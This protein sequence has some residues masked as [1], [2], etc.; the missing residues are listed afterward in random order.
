VFQ[1]RTAEQRREVRQLPAAQHVVKQI[2]RDAI[3]REH[4]QRR[5]L[6]GVGSASRFPLAQLELFSF[7]DDLTALLQLLPEAAREADDDDQDDDSKPQARR[8]STNN[9]PYCRH[10]SPSCTRRAVAGLVEPRIVC[11]APSSSSPEFRSSSVRPSHGD[12]LDLRPTVTFA[13]AVPKASRSPNLLR[14]HL[15]DHRSR[16]LAAPGTS[17]AL[18]LGRRS[19]SCPQPHGSSSSFSWFFFLAEVVSIF[20]VSRDPTAARL[21]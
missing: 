14:E 1:L 8:C 16:D 7:D 6:R 19:V 5:R 17:L 15:L 4:E 3:H 12:S 21:S 2:A 18:A 9:A 13:I 11:T 10:E 20:D